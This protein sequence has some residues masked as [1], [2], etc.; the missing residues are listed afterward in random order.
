RV[1][2]YHPRPEATG[3]IDETTA[4][5]GMARAIC[6]SDITSPL[7]LKVQRDLYNMMAEISAAPENAAKFRV[8]DEERVS[9]L[10]K[11]V[12]FVGSI[13][14]TPEGF[15]VPGDSQA[16]ATLSLARTIVRRSERNLAKLLHDNQIENVE[17]LRYLNRLSSLCFVLELLENQVAG[18]KSHTLA[19]TG[20]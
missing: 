20:E 10:E 16:G 12:D 9:W 6:Q 4:T 7:L 14:E 11:Q 18:K 15:I 17:L 2:K 19:K 13:I 3:L 1:P 8:I 5:I